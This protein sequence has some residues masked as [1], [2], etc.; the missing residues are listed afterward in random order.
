MQT[1]DAGD[2]EGHAFT[3]TINRRASRRKGHAFKNTLM[4]NATPKPQIPEGHVFTRA[5]TATPKA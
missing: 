2:L 3:H 5:I 4:K 1:P